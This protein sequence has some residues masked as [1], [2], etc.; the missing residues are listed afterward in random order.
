MFLSRVL[1]LL[2]AVLPLST[3]FIV[4]PHSFLGVKSGV[5]SSSSIK[6][7]ATFSLPPNAVNDEATAATAVASGDTSRRKFVAAVASAFATTAAVPGIAEAKKN[8]AAPANVPKA[9]DDPF[10]AAFK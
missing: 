7:S 9:P 2:A 5:K 10:K 6:T 8:V 4:L 1:L 3:S